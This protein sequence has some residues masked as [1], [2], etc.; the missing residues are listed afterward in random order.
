MKKGRIGINLV[1]DDLADPPY[2][3]FEIQ[4]VII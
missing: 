1:D 4:S 3:K 2:T